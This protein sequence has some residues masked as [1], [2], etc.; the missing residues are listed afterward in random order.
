MDCHTTPGCG[1][2]SQ[3]CENC[4][5]Q[6]G[7]AEMAEMVASSAGYAIL[8]HPCPSCPSG[9]RAD[10]Q[11]YSDSPARPTDCQ[12]RRCPRPRLDACAKAV[13]HFFRYPA[14]RWH[15]R[16]F[17]CSRATACE[18]YRAAHMLAVY[19]RRVQQRCSSCIKPHV[20]PAWACSTRPPV[21]SVFRCMESFSRRVGGGSLVR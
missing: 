20:S 18:I 2:A 12:Y 9:S 17:L 4:R 14:A 3:S 10:R 7:R 6:V 8:N 16:Q 13:C 11:A 15:C 21:P 5:G 1:R 19:G